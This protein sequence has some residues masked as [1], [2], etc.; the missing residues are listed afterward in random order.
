MI[1]DSKAFFIGLLMMLSFLGIYAYMMSPSFG[2]G[3]NGLEF[4]DDMFNSISKGSVNDVI[5]G[6]VKKIDKW[7]GTEIDVTLPCKDE[8]QADR[9]SAALQKVDGAQV[10]VDGIKVKVKTDLGN[11]LANIAEDCANMFDNNGEAVQQKYGTDPRDA[12]NRWYS[13]TKA[14]IKDLEKQERFKESVAITQFQKKVIEP[15]YNYY[16]V[17]AKQVRDNTGV[18][19]FMMV[20]YLIYTLWYGFAIYYLCQGL[21]ITMSKAA[22]K[23]EA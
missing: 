16:G 21:G 19:T 11:L 9:W 3:R 6:E 12:T 15:S 10:S 2:N 14:V 1:R 18:M 13:I 8:A 7:H 20:F 4:A 5:Q 17:E 23:Q 22:K